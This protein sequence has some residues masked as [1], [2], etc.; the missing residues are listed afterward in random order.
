MVTLASGAR[1]AIHRTAEAVV[2]ADHPGHALTNRCSGRTYQ[3]GPS[4]CNR[5]ASAAVTS[6]RFASE[7]RMAR[8]SAFC[9]IVVGCPKPQYWTGAQCLFSG[10]RQLGA[11]AS[12]TT[13]HHGAL[14]WG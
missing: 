5:C 6:T 14:V 2:S 13:M 9:N 10:I 7:T 11:A 8:C 12:A 4:Q 1:A 3:S